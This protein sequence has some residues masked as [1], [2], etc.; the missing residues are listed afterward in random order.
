MLER[1]KEAIDRANQFG[2]LLIDLSK[3]FDCFD[4]KLIIVKVYEYDVSWS[5]LNI[6]SSKLKHRTPRT[7]INDG[8]SVRLNIEYSIPQGSILGP[9]LLD[10][11]GTLMQI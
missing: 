6:I 2:A 4:R 9:L 7:K 8:F 5:S 11:K 3:A 1:F 10:I